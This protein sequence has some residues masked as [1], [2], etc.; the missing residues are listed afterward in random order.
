[1]LAA[2]LVMSA[3]SSAPTPP[4]SGNNNQANGNSNGSN[5][6][7][8]NDSENNGQ[9]AEETPD[10]ANA[11]EQ[12]FCTM[13]AKMCPD[14]SYVG[15]T[16]PNCEFAACPGEGN[17]LT[18]KEVPEIRRIMSPAIVF[19]SYMEENIGSVSTKK[20]VLGGNWMVTNIENS[21]EGEA[22][23]EYEDGHITGKMQIKYEIVDDK[24]VIKEVKELEE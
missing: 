15:R 20:P 1:M 14:G 18:I 9:I 11:G 22:V 24:V 10:Q 5:E 13:D 16:G 23:V 2:M 4:P 12:V 17:G 3:C 6:S 7:S 19:E 21:G 8:N